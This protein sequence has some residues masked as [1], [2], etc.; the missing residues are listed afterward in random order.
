MCVGSDIASV[1]A[2]RI[3]SHEGPNDGSNFRR[4]SPDRNGTFLTLPLAISKIKSFPKC[5]PAPTNAI[6]FSAG[7]TATDTYDWPYIGH[8]SSEQ[9]DS[10]PNVAMAAANIAAF[11]STD[12]SFIRNLHM[13]LSFAVV[14]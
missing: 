1:P 3:S 11:V 12:L 2:N 5:A 9:L 10:G 8:P 7:A 13:P 4:F 6:R 14:R